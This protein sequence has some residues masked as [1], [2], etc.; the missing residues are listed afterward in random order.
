MYTAPRRPQQPPP[1]L[2]LRCGRLLGRRKRYSRSRCNH[3]VQ[4]GRTKTG[5]PN[6]KSACWWQTIGVARVRRRLKITFHT[7]NVC[8]FR[9]SCYKVFFLYPLLNEYPR[10]S[11]YLARPNLPP[12]AILPSNVLATRDNSSDGCTD[13]VA[14]RRCCSNNGYRC[15]DSGA[16][17][18]HN[19]ICSSTMNTCRG[20]IA[21]GVSTVDGHQRDTVGPFVPS[22]TKTS[23]RLGQSMSQRCMSLHLCAQAFCSLALH[24]P[25]QALVQA[26]LLV[27]LIFGKH[28]GRPGARFEVPRNR[29][30]RPWR[31][32]HSTLP[33]RSSGGDTETGVRCAKALTQAVPSLWSRHSGVRRAGLP[34]RWRQRRRSRRL[35]AERRLAAQLAARLGRRRQTSPR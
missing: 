2:G 26:L 22:K 28:G 27:A 17:E 29:L 32:G 25:Q 8:R 1:E 14:M 4:T 9:S 11:R 15:P 19:S 34:P 7:E 5:A 24:R 6:A 31:P 20:L 10:S 35:S 30:R 3:R 13:Q 16:A 21:Y 23:T 33:P 12:S 18:V